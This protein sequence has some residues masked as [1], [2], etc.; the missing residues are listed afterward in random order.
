MQYGNVGGGS[1]RGVADSFAEHPSNGDRD[2]IGG[3]DIMYLKNVLLKFLDSVASGR[4]EQVS[5]RLCLSGSRSAA[6]DVSA[7]TCQGDSVAWAHSMYRP[8]SS[9][10]LA[11]SF[12]CMCA[13]ASP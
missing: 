7:I 2:H 13:K 9:F 10:G 3:V 1:L 6:G 5:P 12:H 11:M 4:S 8:S